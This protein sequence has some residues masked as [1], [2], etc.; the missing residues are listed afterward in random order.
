MGARRV[1]LARILLH[2]IGRHMSAR[3]DPQT[4]QPVIF[5][6]DAGAYALGL[7]CF[8]AFG[9]RSLCVAAAPVELITRS[10]FFDIVHIEPGAS[11]ESRMAVLRSVAQ[12]NQGKHLLL[13]ANSD[14]V[15]DFFARVR[16]ELQEHYLIPFPDQATIDMLGNKDSFAR[17]CAEQG[18]KTPPTV[19]VDLSEVESPGWEPPSINFRFPVVAKSSSGRAYDEVTFEGKKKIWYIDT[20]AELDELWVMLKDAGFR[21]KFLVQELIPG[22]DT[23][24]RSL[25]F[26]VDSN[27][28]VTLRSA[29]QVLLQDPSPTMIGNPVA[30]ITQPLPEMWELAEKVLAAGNYRGFANFDIKI[31]PRDGTPYFF[32]VNPRIGRNSY[33]V[34]AAGVNPMAVMV[35]DLVAKRR[36]AAVEASQAALYSLVPVSL[37]RKYVKEPDLRAQVKELVK[38]GHVVNP[39]ESPLETDLKRK[40]VVFAQKFN[41]FKKFHRHYRLD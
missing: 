13:L 21:D 39:L 26:Y 32:E 15:I 25:T 36:L 17:V 9:V 11:D 19:V 6:G 34:V 40:A 16:S 33:Y 29:A 28:R 23:H 2:P 37:I 12:Q 1:A 5:G 20:P 4:I 7:E 38:R 41:Y 10:K 31:D 35:E 3:F 8:E 27:G 30:M 18:A 24:M 22:D 14:G